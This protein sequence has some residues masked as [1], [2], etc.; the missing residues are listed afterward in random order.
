MSSQSSFRALPT[1]QARASARSL[2]V[3]RARAAIKRQLHRGELRLA[4]VIL[5]DES[6]VDVDLAGG[7]RIGEVLESPRGIGERK[8]D[9]LLKLSAV[10]GNPR[11]GTIPIGKR[12]R[13]V[14]LVNVHASQRHDAD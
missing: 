10:I 4:D 5:L 3:R 2:E 11:V 9:R 7:M 1:R 13:L 14:E 8:A 6:R 12:R